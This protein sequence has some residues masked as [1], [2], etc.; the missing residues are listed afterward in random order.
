MALPDVRSL[1]EHADRNSAHRSDSRPDR[2]SPWR[3]CQPPPHQA[4]QQ[5]QLLRSARHSRRPIIQP[6]PRNCQCLRA[7]HCGKPSRSRR[8]KLRSA[9]AICCRAGS[10]LPWDSKQC[11]P[12]ILPR[13][14]KRMT[15]E[16]FARRIRSLRKPAPIDLRVFILVKPPFMRKP[17]PCIGRQRSLDF[18][19]DCG[20]TAA[21]LIPTRGGNGAMEALA[22]AGE[23]APPRLR[24]A[25]S[26]RSIMGSPAKGRVFADFGI[27]KRFSTAAHV[28][29]RRAA[30]LRQYES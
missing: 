23:F 14:N 13:L 7:R 30:R 12:T 21:T 24:H 19:F 17:K 6:S 16:Q 15:L 18:A 28:S 26:M 4:L 27:S 3:A 1:E 22:R 2:L 5:R 20:A 25:R 11:T 10:K 9:S 8:R 29:K